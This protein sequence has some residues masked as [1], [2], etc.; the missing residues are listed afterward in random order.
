MNNI[1]RC[2]WCEGQ[3]ELLLHYHDEEWGTPF[4][5]DNKH[6]EFLVLETQQAG[7]SW[8]TILKKRANFKIAFD[9]FDPKL[10]AKYDAKKV[11]QLMGNPGIIRNQRKI[12]A[13][14]NNAQRF[15]EIQKEFGSFDNYIWRFVGNKPVMNTWK[16]ISDIPASTPLSDEISQNLKKRGFK[17]VGST[18]LY[19]HI[20]AIGLVNDHTTKC[21]RYKELVRASS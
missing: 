14:I 20:Q 3:G 17:F 9:G 2:Q 5:S 19:A 18:T 12:E 21:F 10:V 16:I 8:L 15:I 13:T 4:H 1:K 7:L 11:S 6:F